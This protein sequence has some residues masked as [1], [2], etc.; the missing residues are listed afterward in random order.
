M[1]HKDGNQIAT[2][3]SISIERRPFGDFLQDDATAMMKL[4]LDP[5]HSSKDSA[6]ECK[7]AAKMSSDAGGKV[8]AHKFL[9][10]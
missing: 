9:R 8:S 3:T 5:N 1:T 6:E 7:G 10:I 2:I 4:D